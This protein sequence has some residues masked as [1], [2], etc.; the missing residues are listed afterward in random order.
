MNPKIK[1]LNIGIVLVL[2][3]ITALVS[4]GWY[5]SRPQSNV[6][7]ENNYQQPVGESKESG[8]NQPITQVESKISQTQT[9]NEVTV[10]LTSAK[11]IE[12]GVQVE[13]CYPTPD[14]GDWYPTPGSLQYGTN[15]FLPDEF[16]FISEEKA[17][18]IHTGKRCVLVRY[19]INNVES[20]T[21][22]V[23]VTLLS[24]WAV[25]REVPPCENIM[26]RLDTNPQA[27]AYGLNATCSYD[28][29]TGIAVTL[30]E[31]SP[32]IVQ[33]EAQQALDE[34]VRG[35]VNGPWTFTISTLEK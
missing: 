2:T 19:W 35:E 31:H 18:G 4:I 20:I 22:P 17:D 29:Q 9:V 1:T 15:E 10:E 11:L 5:I 3:M 14:N 12:T 8:L 30:S 27:K 24:Y 6:L 28:D 7:A 25:P 33:E 13:L 23:Q 16:E 32:S 26:Q 21:T 34:I